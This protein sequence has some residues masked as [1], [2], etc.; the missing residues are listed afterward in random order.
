MLLGEV[1]LKRAAQHLFHNLAGGG[2]GRDGGGIHDFAVAH[3]G[4]AFTDLDDLVDAVGNKNN[5]DILRFLKV[6]DQPE[7]LG[8]F[9]IAQR[10][11]RLVKDQKIAFVGY[12][13]GNQDHLLLRQRQVLHQFTHIYVDV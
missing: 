1:F 13:S 3:H 7:K 5:G 4:V 12:G 9:R 6:L 11:G 8:G 10:S 2:L